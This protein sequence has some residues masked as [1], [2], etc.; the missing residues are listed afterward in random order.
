[1]IDKGVI[2][3]ETV[4]EMKNISK[5]NGNRTEVPTV[6]FQMEK[7]KCV[8]IRCNRIIGN[9]FIQM[10]LGNILPSTGEI[11][12]N[13]KKSSEKDHIFR[14]ISVSSLQD[15]LYE[16]MRVADYLSFFKKMYRSK[17]SVDE[18]LRLIGLFDKKN[19]KI[20]KLH[21]SEQKRVHIARMMVQDTNFIILE[22]PEQNIDRE[23]AIIIRNVIQQW[24]EE[25]K[26]ILIT[27]SFLEDALSF[28]DALYLL[29]EEGLKQIEIMEETTMDDQQSVLVEN[30]P[31]KLEKIPA[32]VKDKMILFDPLEIHFI[33]SVEGVT[34]LHLS[35]GSFACSFTLNELEKKLKAFGFFRCH[36]SYIVN[37]QRVREIITWTRNSYSLILDNEQKSSIPL[38]KARFDEWKEAIGL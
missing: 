28:A 2:H 30:Y 7:S 22:E 13:G 11:N 5:R 35:E 4:L 20:A 38:S 1:M 14:E 3:V 29:N 25:E 17:K 15:G 33:E 8:V 37:L 12:V 34:F 23:G 18:V 27:T 24:K 6:H 32:K 10:I 31:L 9:T 19:V 16:R 36:R 26:A 21:F